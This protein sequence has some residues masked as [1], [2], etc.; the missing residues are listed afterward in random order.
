MDKEES[1][2]LKKGSTKTKISLL[3]SGYVK[4]S[5]DKDMKQKAM[6]ELNETPE[7]YKQELKVIENLVQSN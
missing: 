1:P 6:E 2:Q 7:R 5:M 3:K 4:Y